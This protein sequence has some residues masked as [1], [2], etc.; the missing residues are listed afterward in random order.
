MKEHFTKITLKDLMIL[1]RLDRSSI[2]CFL[3]LRIYGGA[4]GYSWASQERISDD[5]GVSLPS[6]RRSFNKLR[7]MGF[8][9]RVKS[10]KRS[11]THRIN[12]ISNLIRTDI[13]SDINDISNLIKT[14]IKSDI[15]ID[16]EKDKIKY[17]NKLKNQKS[18]NTQNVED[19]VL[20]SDQNI[21]D[22]LIAFKQCSKEQLV[23]DDLDLLFEKLWTRHSVTMSWISSDPIGDFHKIKKGF[24]RT[25]IIKTLKL[26]DFLIKNNQVSSS[27][28]KG[29][30][31][32]NG[33]QSWFKRQS[34]EWTYSDSK[35][36]SGCIS[37]SAEELATR[38]LKI[39]R[40]NLLRIDNQDKMLGGTRAR[41]YWASIVK[42]YASHEDRYNAVLAA[43]IYKDSLFVKQ[44]KSDPDLETFKLLI[45]MHETLY[46]AGGE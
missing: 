35:R 8:I 15:Q 39:D 42:K 32:I 40:Q 14:D 5:T 17:I 41:D 31:W 34:N 38:K 37:V 25:Q 4:D 24:S 36:F 22:S 10:K 23:I 21:S 44:I 27:K 20:S 1:S 12:D 33:M 18:L 45:N 26:I 43:E 28:W 11:C 19:E 2:L 6:I 29:K 7:K 3:A 13:K 16:K 46:A 30:N 9:T